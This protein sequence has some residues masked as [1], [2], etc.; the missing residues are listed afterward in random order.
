MMGK[1]LFKLGIF[2]PE[3]AEP[4]D[5]GYLLAEVAERLSNREAEW[6]R[7]VEYFENDELTGYWRV[8]V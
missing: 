1:K 8:E 7:G 5:I 6:P 4:S 3:D 2:M